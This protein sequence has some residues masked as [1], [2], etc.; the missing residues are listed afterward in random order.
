MN[1]LI[2]LASTLV[3][4]G[5]TKEIPTA[6]Y[7]VWYPNDTTET[8]CTDRVVWGEYEVLYKVYQYDNGNTMLF[9]YEDG[10]KW[11][12][13]DGQMPRTKMEFTEDKLYIHQLV[14][15]GWKEG[16]SPLVWEECRPSTVGCRKILEVN[17]TLISWRQNDKI[18]EFYLQK[19]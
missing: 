8:P 5:C 13:R 14:D 16:D 6:E 7:D 10:P 11:S 12:E 3:A 4:V 19:L 18:I 17:D 1:K 15:Q 2:L 9:A